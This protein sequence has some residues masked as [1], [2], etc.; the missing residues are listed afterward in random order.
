MENLNLKKIKKDYL[1]DGVTIIRNFIDLHWIKEMQIAIDHILS[2]PG[3]A[4]IEYTPQ[5]NTGRYYGDFFIWRRNKSFKK[6]AFDSN[7]PELASKILDSKNINF[8]YDQLLVKEPKTKESTPWHH[9]LPYWPIKGN[10]IISFWVGF[11]RVSKN[12]GAVEYIKGSHKWNKF[13]APASFGKDTR[14]EN[15]YKKMGLEVMPDINSNLGDYELLSWDLNPGDIIIHHPLV[16]HG[17]LGNFSSKT[18]RRG[19]AL[20]YIGDDVTWDDRPGTFIKNKNVKSILPPLNYKNGEALTG[21]LFPLI[22]PNKY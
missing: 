17:S 7:L 8:F 21:D 13:F 18:R 5:E 9:D 2:F 20:R 12:T 15:S 11:D 4:S 1:N 16:I 14:F 22:W 6:F 19:L 3:K 10:H